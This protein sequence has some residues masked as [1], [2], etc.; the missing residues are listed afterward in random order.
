MLLLILSGLV[1]SGQQTICGVPS[2]DVSGKK[3]W[4][5]QHQTV[6]RSWNPD[7]RWIQTNAFGR[8][9]GH[10]LELD[11]TWFNLESRLINQSIGS[12]G[13]KWSPRRNGEDSK[14]PLRFVAGEMLQFR[15]VGPKAGN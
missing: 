2:A 5:Y 14:I 10:A 8:G 6:A 11:A 15:G 13:F 3:E 1:A 7:R 4:F 9:I 12:I